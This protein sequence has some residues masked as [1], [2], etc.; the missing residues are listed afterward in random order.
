MLTSS[1]FSF[2][3]QPFG[4]ICHSHKNNAE[5][6]CILIITRRHTIHFTYLG[7]STSS[8]LS[9]PINT[10]MP[11]GITTKCSTLVRLLFNAYKI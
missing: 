4:T 11:Y 3:F 9:N 8:R 5:S 7:K 2:K 10:T 6:K 1:N